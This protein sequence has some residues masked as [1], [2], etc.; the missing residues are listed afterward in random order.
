[1]WIVNTRNIE[2]EAVYIE[3]IKKTINAQLPDH[4]NDPGIFE[5]VKTY[6][7]MRNLKVAGNT[8]RINAS[9]HTVDILLRRQLSQNHLILNLAMLK[10]KKF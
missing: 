4:L 10:S 9:S 2:N 5:L 6:K 8:V 1:M 3:F 7:C